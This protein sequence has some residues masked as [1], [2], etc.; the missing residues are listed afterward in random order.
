M[1]K[2]KTKLCKL[3]ISIRDDQHATRPTH[4]GHPVTRQI[5]LFDVYGMAKCLICGVTWQRIRNETKLLG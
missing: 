5:G 2:T 1:A 4:V 3:C